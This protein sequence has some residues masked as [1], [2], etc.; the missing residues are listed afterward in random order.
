MASVAM[1]AIGDGVSGAVF[2]VQ[3]STRREPSPEPRRNCM[4]IWAK[5]PGLTRDVIL[6]QIVG[7]VI[8][9]RAFVKTGEQP[10]RRLATR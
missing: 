9:R 8:G 1:M 5:H 4:R 10:V 6:L 2:P 3:H 7:G